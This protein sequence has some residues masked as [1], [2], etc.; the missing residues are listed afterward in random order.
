[1]VDK[2][3]ILRKLAELD[4]YVRQAGEYSSISE[5]EY[6]NDWKVQRIVDRTLQLAIEVCVDVT[7]HVISD[8]EFRVPT[9]YADTFR[10]MEENKIVDNELC[11]KLTDMCSFRNILIHEYADVDPSI[12]VSV[13]EKD[14]RDFDQ[15]KSA[16]LAFIQGSDQ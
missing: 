8:R 16:I 13:L 14:L 3:L 9:T 11:E 6:E 4:T 15:F 1:M 12:V 10:V 5:E 2:N 7:N